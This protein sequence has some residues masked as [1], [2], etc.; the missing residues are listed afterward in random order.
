MLLSY[1]ARNCWGFKEWMEVDMRVGKKASAG[2]SFPTQRV[3]P[4]MCFEGANASG[5]T[6]GL[7][8]LSFIYDFCLNSFQYAPNSQIL[9][10]TYFHND[11]KSEFYITFSMN[12]KTDTEYT[13]EAEIDKKKVYTEKLTKRQGRSKKIMLERKGNS[14]IKN[15]LC[16]NQSG[17]IYKDT[18]SFIS[19]LLQ[20]GVEEIKPF[21]EFFRQVNSNVSYDFTR[22][23]PM[24]D[25]VAQYYYS[26]PELHKR[27]VKQLQDWDTGIVDIDILTTQ[28]VNGRPVYI[29]LFT[30]EAGEEKKKLL[31]STQSNGT[32][33]LYNRLKDFFIA[34][35]TGGVLIFDEL[36]THLHSELVPLLLGYFIDP[37]RNTK[38]AQ[39]IFSTHSTAL[40]DT[41]KKYRIYL[42]KKI[43][44]ESIC[45]RIDELEGN[46]LLRNDRSLE[47]LYKA[48][49]LGGLPDVR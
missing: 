34:L 23:D 3:V 19:T 30:H 16:P 39:L 5:K 42:F 15:V 29:S 37:N 32:K 11:D 25:Y 27:V 2:V 24:T 35:D 40:M 6:C 14:I 43:R 45:Y 44:G 22:D 10:D 26:H 47:E 9:Y 49:E 38:N 18:A 7:R 36:D 17:I 13:Y 4:A 8:V 21:G 12:S 33:L 48:G 46:C 31:F 1:G 20:Y 28:D 41:L